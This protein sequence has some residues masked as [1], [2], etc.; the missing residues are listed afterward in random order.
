MSWQLK[1]WNELFTAGYDPPMSQEEINNAI[2]YLR[3]N[4]YPKP[5]DCP[6]QECPDYRPACLLGICHIVVRMC[7]DF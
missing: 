1:E 4:N 3:A 7:G 5:E 2:R 6:G